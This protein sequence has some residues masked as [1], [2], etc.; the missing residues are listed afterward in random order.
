M[1]RMVR[2]ILEIF[3]WFRVVTRVLIFC[4]ACLEITHC[5]TNEGFTTRTIPL[6]ENHTL[7]MTIH[8]RECSVFINILTYLC[9]IFLTHTHTYIYIYIYTHIYIYIYIYMCIYIY[10]YICVCVR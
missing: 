2:M 8:G 6:I 10:I 4:D 3:G 7:K 9:I 5:F 1:V